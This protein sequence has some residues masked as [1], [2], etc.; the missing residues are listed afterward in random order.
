MANLV[1]QYTKKGANNH[2]LVLCQLSVHP[3]HEGVKLGIILREF[4]EISSSLRAVWHHDILR[5]LDSSARAEYN[6]RAR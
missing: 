6:G 3:R 2:L 4:G 5:A 1:V